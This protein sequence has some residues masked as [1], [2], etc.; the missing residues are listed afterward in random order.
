MKKLFLILSL[1]SLNLMAINLPPIITKA[2]DVAN[3]NANL[4]NSN[5]YIGGDINVSTATIDTLETLSSN[6]NN[7]TGNFA[8]FGSVNISNSLSLPNLNANIVNSNYLTGIDI[9][10]STGTINTLESLSINSNNITSNTYNSITTLKTYNLLSSGYFPD[11]TDLF[12]WHNSGAADFDGTA[13]IGSKDLT[14]NGTGLTSST[15]HLG[16]VAYT[17]F[18]GTDDYLS[19]TDATFDTADEDF[20][21]YAWVRADA[22][23]S[24][25]VIASKYEV[26]GNKISWQLK[27]DAA[28]LYFGV[29]YN[30]TN[31]VA[32][33]G[34]DRNIL[35]DLKYHFVAITY[36]YVS[37]NESWMLMMV[38]GNIVGYQKNATA[39]QGS[40]YNS[41]D[42]ELK[43]GARSNGGAEQFWAGDIDEPGYKKTALTPNQLRKIYNAGSRKFATIDGNG[44]VATIDGRKN[45]GEYYIYPA[46]AFTITATAVGTAAT[47][48][49]LYIPEDGKYKISGNFMFNVSDAAAGT[50]SSSMSLRIVGGSAGTTEIPGAYALQVLDLVTAGGN[51]TPGTIV[52]HFLD[53]I[54]YA[55]TNDIINVETWKSVATNSAVL[56]YVSDNYEP[57]FAWEKLD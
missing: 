22:I 34:P 37:A 41:A 46:A 29:S 20:T 56:D 14:E 7:V 17:K 40:R 15:N 43:I 23:A 57:F 13:W 48:Y 16:T 11:T 6:S 49:R 51:N 8:T 47:G 2:I 50:T 44:K 36:D 39:G 32:L 19:T 53:T 4:T 10:T 26:S 28:N 25:K 54:I 24:D 55:K 35:G 31:Q 9:K 5:Y 3:I 1:I 52:Q 30:G 21:F 42:S 12:A 33:F 45:N 27:M 18:N 38:D